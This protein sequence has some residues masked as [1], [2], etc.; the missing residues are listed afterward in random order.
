MKGTHH[1]FVS[2]KIDTG[3]SADT[4]VYL[5]KKRR[6]DLDKPDAPEIGRCCEAGHIADYAA[7]Q[8]NDQIMPVKSVLDQ[9]SVDHSDV[10]EGLI[11]LTGRKDAG[12]Y[13]PETCG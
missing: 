4:A 9:H 3:L 11:R 5:R 8:G 10:V 1:I 13:R 2:V 12:A 6:R 7:A